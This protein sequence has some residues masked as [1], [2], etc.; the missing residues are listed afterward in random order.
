MILTITSLILAFAVMILGA[1]LLVRGA[2]KLALMFG[3]SEL[4]IGLSIV[5]FGTSA[6][7][8][9]VS[10]KGAI[11]GHSDIVVGNC[12]GSNIFNLLFI[13]GACASIS[14][15]VVVKQLVKVDVPIMIGAHLL[16]LLLSIDGHLNHYNAFA[17]VLIFALYYL[18][19]VRKS[20]KEKSLESLDSN[21]KQAI[22]GKHAKSLYGI[23]K[24]SS[25][26]MFGLIMCIA[27]ANSAVDS[28]II[29]ANYLKVSELIIGLTIVS[30]G[31][32]LP[33]VA[34]SVVATCR[35]KKDLAL[36]NIIGSSIFNILG[37]IGLAGL[38]APKGIIV[39]PSIIRF[40]LPVAIISAIACLPIFFTGYRISRWEGVLFLLY[41]VAYI[42]Y[43]CLEATQHDILPVFSSVMLWFT[44]PLTTLTLG[45]I[46]YR[47]IRFGT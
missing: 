47:K 42:A 39:A 2:S 33:E 9:I 46:S 24:Y 21:H 13:I 12:V 38:F 7:E 28:S 25:F 26:V 36:G 3:I 37:V 4:V 17:L 34:T 31:T 44:I 15:L 22:Q 14:P 41:Y 18:F 29:I 1:E 8:F 35:G 19:I 10:I 11:T 43:L 5:A 20:L 23:I 16:F 27:G 30:I 6:P 45:L 32:S 40:D